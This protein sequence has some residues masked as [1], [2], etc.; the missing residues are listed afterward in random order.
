MRTGAQSTAI[1]NISI[2]YANAT[3]VRENAM[4]KTRGSFP[5]YPVHALSPIRVGNGRSHQLTPSLLYSRT[6]A[7]TPYARSGP[8]AP[9]IGHLQYAVIFPLVAHHH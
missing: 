1:E 5:I 2:E 3:G 7:H 8:G 4:G 9:I 6:G